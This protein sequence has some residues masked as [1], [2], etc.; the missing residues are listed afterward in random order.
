MLAEVRLADLDTDF[1]TLRS[2][3]TA[4]EQHPDPFWIPS[5]EERRGLRRG[6]AAKLIFDI[7]G[8]NPD[9]SVAVE[10]ERMWVIVSEVVGT[11]FVGI[12]DNQPACLD[13]ES[14][15]YLK[16]GVEVPFAPEHVIDI[17]SPPADLVEWQLG[18]TPEL[19]WPR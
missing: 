19:T 13:P 8:F 18:Q 9:G 7:E 12:L 16:F 5:I 1:W 15:A 6:D 10:G 3:E 17:A 2:G 14:N 4:H 11:L